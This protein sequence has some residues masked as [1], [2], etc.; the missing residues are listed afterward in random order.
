MPL[1][2]NIVVLLLLYIYCSLS[3]YSRY[4]PVCIEMKRHDALVKTRIRI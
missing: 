2:F 4:I 3:L 1:Q